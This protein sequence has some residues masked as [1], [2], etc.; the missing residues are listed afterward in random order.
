[1]NSLSDVCACVCFRC[2][3]RSQGTV[4]LKCTLC[5]STALHECPDVLSASVPK[6]WQKLF[7]LVKKMCLQAPLLG[8]SKQH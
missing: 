2:F 7:A 8:T 3:S 4:H 6:Q 1:M 5:P